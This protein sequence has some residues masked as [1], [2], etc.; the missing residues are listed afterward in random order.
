MIEQWFVESLGMKQ[1]LLQ[2]EETETRNMIISCGIIFTVEEMKILY[3]IVT[4]AVLINFMR[5]GAVQL[6]PN[7]HVKVSPIYT[8]PYQVP[9]MHIKITNHHNLSS[10]RMW[11]IWWC[12]NYNHVGILNSTNMYMHKQSL[13]MC[14]TLVH[15]CTFVYIYI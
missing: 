6:Y 8:T 11:F 1:L 5:M 12:W 14:V 4:S 10:T 7:I 9:Y 2:T 13:H 3:T 15:V